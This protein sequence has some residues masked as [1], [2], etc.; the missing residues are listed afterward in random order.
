MKLFLLAASLLLTCLPAWAQVIPSHVK[1]GDVVYGRKF[2]FALT[3]DVF[4]PDK[5]NG[6]A[7]IYMVSGGWVSGYS[8]NTPPIYASFLERGYTV[9][10]VRHAC[11]PKF[12]IPEITQ[13]IHR[14]IRYIRYHAKTWNLNPEK[15][16]ISG[17][18][19][20]GHLSLTLGVQGGP[21]NPESKDPVDRESSAIQAIA[22]LYPPTDFLNYGKTG[23]DAVGVGILKNYKAAFGPESD[24]PEGRLRL[25]KEVSP[26]YRI[27]EKLPPTFIIHGDKDE[28]V[29][30]QQ[31][32]LFVAQATAAG[33]IAKLVVKPGAAHGWPD[34]Q[35]D[36]QQFADWFDEHLRG[37]KK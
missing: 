22:C 11:Q 2:G 3:L 34:R 30:M 31:S 12:T 36:Y 21:G 29:P 26:I 27:T 32:Q 8:P 33:A 17:G 16:G 4:Q 18:S 24:T 7:I 15:F 6:C 19:A 14:A 35:P 28:L 5:P 23:E 10:S 25:G 9:F 37:L 13:D 20:G 1:T